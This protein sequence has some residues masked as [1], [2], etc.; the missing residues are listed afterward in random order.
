[1]ILDKDQ[2]I[3]FF[4]LLV[5]QFTGEKGDSSS[6]NENF[7]EPLPNAAVPVQSRWETTKTSILWALSDLSSRILLSTAT[8]MAFWGVITAGTAAYKYQFESE[9]AATIYVTTAAAEI[10]TS[11]VNVQTLFSEGEYMHLFWYVSEAAIA[12][13]VGTSFISGS[14][15]TLAELAKRY[16]MKKN[17]V[18]FIALISFLQIGSGIFRSWAIIDNYRLLDTLKNAPETISNVAKSE[19]FQTVVQENSYA[20]GEVLGSAFNTFLKYAVL[21]MGSAVAKI[22]KDQTGE[23][24]KA[25]NF[26]EAGKYV[27][28]VGA[29]AA[30]V[31]TLFTL[32]FIRSLF[33][34]VFK[35][36]A[37]TNKQNANKA[38]SWFTGTSVAK[39]TFLS[40]GGS[41]VASSLYNGGPGVALAGLL[42][43]SKITRYS[44]EI[45]IGKDP[46]ESAFRKKRSQN[47][48]HV[49]V[50]AKGA[51]T[52]SR[53]VQLGSLLAQVTMLMYATSGMGGNIDAAHFLFENRYYGAVTWSDFLLHSLEME[54]Y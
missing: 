31:G 14:I 26:T 39:L 29:L 47:G 1:M 25:G 41:Y 38:D 19:E 43:C 45:C 36:T 24:I 2:A 44:L 21:P 4:K 8:T 28:S 46:V 30:S 5:R 3:L 53:F 22:I 27:L 11:V 20:M 32:N 12:G 13:G 50:L 15:S 49:L 18:V 10:L 23:H 54:S 17:P 7:V 35:K 34:C 40:I 51:Y 16:G 37:L 9:T 42:I 48:P 33:G 52:V 6:L